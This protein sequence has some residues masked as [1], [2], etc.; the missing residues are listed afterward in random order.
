MRIGRFTTPSKTNDSLVLHSSIDFR[1][2]F[3]RRLMDPTVNTT[4]VFHAIAAVLIVGGFFLSGQLL[5]VGLIGVGVVLF[6]A[7]IVVARRDD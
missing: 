2:L 5:T 7:G 4:A 6:V 3:H 1:A